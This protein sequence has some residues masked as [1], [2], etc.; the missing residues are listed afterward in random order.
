MG[1]VKEVFE[2]S[3]LGDSNDIERLT[4]GFNLFDVTATMEEQSN[5]L[6]NFRFLTQLSAFLMSSKIES[7]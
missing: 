1:A 2:V 3:N 5:S 6:T 4:F 7:C